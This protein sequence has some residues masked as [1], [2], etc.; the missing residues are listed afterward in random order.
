MTRI[1]EWMFLG[2]FMVMLGVVPALFAV[3]NPYE[4]A[5]MTYL[6]VDVIFTIARRIEE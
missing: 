1:F 6:F 5:L 4:T 2:I 3:S